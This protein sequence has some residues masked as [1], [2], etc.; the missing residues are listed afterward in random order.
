[1]PY[2]KGHEKCAED[3]GYGSNGAANQ[4]LQADL[5]HTLLENNDRASKGETSQ[6]SNDAISLK[7]PQEVGAHA[8]NGDK[9]DTNNNQLD[10][11]GTSPGAPANQAPDRMSYNPLKIS[12]NPIAGNGCGNYT[13]GPVKLLRIGI[14]GAGGVARSIHLPGFKL[15]PQVEIAAVCDPDLEAARG[16]GIARVFDRVEDLLGLSDVDAVVVATPNHLHREIVMSALAA[17]KHVLCEKPLALNTADARGMAEAAAASGLV[18]MTAFT[19]RFTPGLQYMRRLV[20]TGELGV[21]RTVRAAYLMALS[22]H[23]LGWRSTRRLAGSG[24]LADIGSHLIHMVQFLAGDIFALTAA[25]RRF[26]EDPESDVEDWISF[27]AEFAGGACGTFEISRVCAGRGAGISEDIFIELYGSQ[28]SAVFS[29]QDPFALRVALGPEAADPSCPLVRREVPAE[30]LKIPGS[31]RDVQAD[32]PR[33][34][35]RYDQAW[36]F[37]ESVRMGKPRAPTFTDGE[38]CQAVLDAALE[39]SETRTWVRIGA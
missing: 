12:A 23:L 13:I 7:R 9:D 5:L 15:C 22:K 11:E 34:G 25:R 30:F 14:I 31:P 6:S 28:G 17:G 27:L 37:A 35:Y 2:D 1:M 4:P 26:R 16:L 29:L 33:W 10:Q 18:H 19:Y 21:L 3:P 38:R 8:Q 39:S 24:V 36:Q 20:E 32:D